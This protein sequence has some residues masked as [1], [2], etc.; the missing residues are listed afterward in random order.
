MQE[1]TAGL[2]KGGRHFFFVVYV[3]KGSS[4]SVAVKEP[5]PLEVNYRHISVFQL[6]E[7]T[8]LIQT[9]S[10]D[11]SWMEIRGTTTAGGTAMG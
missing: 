9:R 2:A 6:P 3:I 8:A 11:F 1:V 5:P 10:L 7:V 4:T